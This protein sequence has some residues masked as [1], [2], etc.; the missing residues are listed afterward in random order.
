LKTVRPEDLEVVRPET[1][2]ALE[3][4]R[5]KGLSKE[6]IDAIIEDLGRPS[7]VLNYDGIPWNNNNAEHAIK[8]FARLRRVLSG[9]STKKG[10]EE[11]S[12]S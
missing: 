3:R 9:T 11:T 1:T 6:P 5:R 12:L 2:C 7:T 10:V 8:V 4:P